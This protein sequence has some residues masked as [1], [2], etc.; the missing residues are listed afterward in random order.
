[1]KITQTLI[2][3]FSKIGK[4]ET[5]EFEQYLIYKKR[6]KLLEIFSCFKSKKDVESIEASFK[7]K[8]INQNIR[9][10]LNE[11]LEL[12]KRFW[13]DRDDEPIKELNVI[14]QIN[15]ASLLHKKG[16]YSH[17]I[18]EIKAVEQLSSEY[19][20]YQ[21]AY[22]SNN[23]LAKWSK[24]LYPEN[25]EQLA[26][27]QKATAVRNH[28]LMYL[29]SRLTYLGNRMMYMLHEGLWNLNENQLDFL[30][31]V[32]KETLKL[33][34]KEVITNNIKVGLLQN[35]GYVSWMIK[36]DG[37]AACRYARDTVELLSN[38]SDSYSGKDL[39]KI[40]AYSFL[41]HQL[42]LKNKIDEFNKRFEELE[43]LISNQKETSS[44][45]EYIYAHA[46]TYSID[47]NITNGEMFNLLIDRVISFL[48]EHSSK[49]SPKFIGG[50]NRGLFDIYFYK[51]EFEVATEYLDNVKEVNKTKNPNLKF[52]EL[53]GEVLLA[54]EKGAH[55]YIINRCLSFRRS[56]STYLT[57]NPIGGLFISCLMK[58]CKATTSLERKKILQGY[59]LRIEPLLDNSRH[60]YFMSFYH[61]IPWID[62]KINEFSSVYDY[63]K[64]QEET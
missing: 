57:Y 29:G 18:D 14:N 24:D 31:G 61:L 42:C 60:R 35:L 41:L 40:V 37:E 39:N 20:L 46:I 48:N 9:Y 16:L 1:M 10:N 3:L 8:K 52:Q 49:M 21:F 25:A 36:M 5:K 17:A 22:L 23:K 33:L 13:I 64:A 2:S 55:E 56:A 47:I 6:K 32:E 12:V 11:L 28:D 53:V 7:R 51:G 45:I 63:L 50:L 38:T 15:F 27:Q 4:K 26:E 62:S 44:T 59:K 19:Y 30:Q 34:K 54:Y 43:N 58:L